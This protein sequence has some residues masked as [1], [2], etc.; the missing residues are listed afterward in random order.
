MTPAQQTALRDA[1]HA[2]PACADALAAKDCDALAAIMSAGRTRANSREIGNG[3]ILEVLGIATGNALLDE[4]ASNT[5]YRHVKPLLEQ[6]RLLIGT[7]LAQA[8]VQGFA[9]SILTQAQADALCALGMDSNP[10][11]AADMHEALFNRD[12]SE[13]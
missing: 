10:Y 2:N 6:G 13:K 12:G 1:V 8:T 9:P 5:I 4:L 7:P 11:T 3:T